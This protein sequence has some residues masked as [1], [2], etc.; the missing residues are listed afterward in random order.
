MVALKKKET[1]LEHTP[2]PWI[3]KDNKVKINN[4]ALS[5]FT[6]AECNTTVTWDEDNA[7]FIAKACNAYDKQVEVINLTIRTI[8]DILRL[9]RSNETMDRELVGLLNDVLLPALPEGEV[10]WRHYEGEEE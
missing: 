2:T 1:T 6:I 9:G 8:Q 3:A 5:G 10:G 4:G 7:A